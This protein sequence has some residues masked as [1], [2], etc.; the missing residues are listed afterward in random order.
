ALTLNQPSVMRYPRD[1]V[2]APLLAPGETAT[3]EFELGRSRLLRDGA[4]ATILAY[5]AMC[6]NALAAADLLANE[7]I[8]V[9]VI[10]ARFAKPV[11][12]EMVA[13]ALETGHLVVTIEDH[14]LAG[15]FGSAVI[16][17]A[18]ELGLDTRPIGRIGMPVDRFIPHGSRAAQLAECG[19]DA[20]NIA[21]VIQQAIQSSVSAATPRDLPTASRRLVGSVVRT[22]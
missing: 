12:R 9:R 1:N 4:D 22:D 16:E 19:L 13:A 10:N 17:T 11:D 20:A 3:P 5:G 21:S 7:G 2:P 8:E 14:S 15:G 6:S 18:Q